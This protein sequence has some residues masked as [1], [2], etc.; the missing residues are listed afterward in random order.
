VKIKISKMKK[1][2]SF[3]AVAAIVTGAFAFTPNKTVNYCISTTKGG[4]CTVATRQRIVTSGGT[5]VFYDPYIIPSAPPDCKS[6]DC[7]TPVKIAT[8]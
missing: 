7:S 3:L 6:A 1:L 5:S 4:P 8:N 2:M